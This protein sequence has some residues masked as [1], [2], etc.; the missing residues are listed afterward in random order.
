MLSYDEQ[1]LLDAICQYYEKEFA[2]VVKHNESL[3]IKFEGHPYS[4]TIPLSNM[5]DKRFL[6]VVESCEYSY[7]EIKNM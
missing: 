6:D 2:Y 3:F 5:L 4:L 7:D 1:K